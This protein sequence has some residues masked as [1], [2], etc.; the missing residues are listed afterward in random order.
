MQRL[1]F[2]E[3][4]AEIDGFGCRT[5][6]RGAEP[7]A[8]SDVPREVLFVLLKHRPRPVTG[9]ALLKEI[10]PSGV[11]PSN[12]AKQVRALR[13]ELGDVQS[14]RYIRTLK[15]EGYA[16]VMPVA[17]SPGEGNGPAAPV[18]GEYQLGIAQ[19]NPK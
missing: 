15:K 13:R 16:F 14:G 19:P 6:F 2:G 3:F 10:W 4:S 18:H 7:V 8:L 1:F 12:V 17:E 9:K 11:N 5:L